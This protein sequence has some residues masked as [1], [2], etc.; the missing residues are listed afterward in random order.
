MAWDGER[1][2]I[3][4]AGAGNGAG[5]SGTANRRGDF[6][7]GPCFTVRYRGQRLPHLPLKRRRLHVEQ[8]VQARLTPGNVREDRLGPP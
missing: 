8:Q 6:G 7:V 3:A 5:G 2:S 4:G 1:N